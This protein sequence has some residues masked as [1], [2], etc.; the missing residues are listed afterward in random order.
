VCAALE[1]QYAQLEAELECQRLRQARLTE[2]RRHLT[3]VSRRLEALRTD[4]ARVSRYEHYA[5]YGELLKANLH[6]INKGDERITVVDWF[7]P[8][9]SE[10]V[11]VLDPAKTPRGNMEDYFN[12][13][14]KYVTAKREILP[15][16]AQ[17]DQELATLHSELQ[18]IQEGSW[19]PPASSPQQPSPKEAQRLLQARS[20]SGP[21]RRFTSADGLPIYVGRNAKENE[22]LTLRF[23]HGD[24][25]WLHARGVPGSHVVVR[26]E[27]GTAPPP[28]TLLD[29]ATL[30]LLYS[31][32]KKNGKGEI[33]YT[34]R[35]YV[36]KA[37]GQ[38]LGEVTVTQEKAIH[39]QLDRA[40]LAR[41]KD[42][43]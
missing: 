29:A 21:F 1:E 34:R 27:R 26:L 23:A 16:I 9:Q 39:L 10:L 38:P 24:D 31:E 32:L 13:Y 25:L 7:D 14:R 4:L 6:R 30:A 43:G 22:D 2:L 8:T 36:R 5:R 18:A 41:L 19:R 35:K 17:L 3:K 11:I 12:K 37:K 20:R 42:T 15:R 40:R 33:I 28:E